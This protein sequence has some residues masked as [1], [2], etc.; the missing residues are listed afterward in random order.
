MRYFL[1]EL[2]STEFRVVAAPPQILATQF[3]VRITAEREK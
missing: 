2:E 1:S 3:P